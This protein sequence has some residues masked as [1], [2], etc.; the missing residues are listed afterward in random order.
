MLAGVLAQIDVRGRLA[1]PANAASTARS[2][3]ATNVI[4]DRLCDASDDDVEHVTPST[5]GDRVANRR[6]DFG[7]TAFREIRN[8]FDQLHRAKRSWSSMAA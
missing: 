7:A 1:M 2:S 3:G 6:D 8:A 4:T 5:R